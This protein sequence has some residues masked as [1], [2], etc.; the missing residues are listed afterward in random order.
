[1]PLFQLV[2]QPSDFSSDLSSRPGSTAPK[3]ASQTSPPSETASS[4]GKSGISTKAQIGVGVGVSVGVLA[5][6]LLGF[7]FFRRRQSRAKQGG[8]KHNGLVEARSGYRDASSP[9]MATTAGKYTPHGGESRGLSPSSGWVAE[10]H[11]AG[12]RQIQG[13][14]TELPS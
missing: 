2:H 7:F 8:E 13:P 3:T 4:N 10:R 1:M 11:E 6:L 12:G 14:P 5:L 9:S